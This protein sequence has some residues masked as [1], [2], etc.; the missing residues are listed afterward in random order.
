MKRKE[1][2]LSLVV[3]RKE[4]KLW[5]VYSHSFLMQVEYNGTRFDWRKCRWC[6]LLVRTEL[7]MISNIYIN[8]FVI[9]FIIIAYY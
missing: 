9:P 3:V 1:D 8:K 6:R 5:A 4:G 7:W 2:L